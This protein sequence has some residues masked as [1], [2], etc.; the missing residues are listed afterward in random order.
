[1]QQ[2]PRPIKP[3]QWNKTPLAGVSRIIA[4]ASGKGGVGKSTTTVNLARALNLAGK[5][6]GVLDADIYGPSIPR[7]LGI[8]ARPEIRNDKMLPLEA[9]GIKCLSIGLITGGEGAVIWRAPMLSKALHQMLRLTDWGAKQT[10]GKA[11]LDILLID[12]PPG[13]GDIHLNIVQQVPVDGAI[14]ITTPQ[15]VATQDAAKCAEL[16]T[17][18]G[19]PLLG[20]VENMSYFSA[21]SGGDRHYIFGEGGGK[22]LAAQLDTPLLGEIPLAADISVAADT[23]AVVA[24]EILRSY[25]D[26]A[27]KL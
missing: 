1:M 26:I 27:A 19:V 14:I 8:S 2:T 6:A 20:V 23:G 12:M 11:G 21:P 24:D 5:S 15:E 18:T 16:F 13:T 9:D 25:C 4:V 7:M 17:R 3:A 10:V 22:K